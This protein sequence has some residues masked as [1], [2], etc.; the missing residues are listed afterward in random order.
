MA[1]VWQRPESRTW[2]VLH[3]RQKIK[4]GKSQRAAQ[5][6]AD[7]I[8]VA[9]AEKQ[10]GIVRKLIQPKKAQSTDAYLAYYQDFSTKNHRPSTTKRYGAVIRT[11]QTFLQ[12]HF[13]HVTDLADLDP[14]VFERYKIWRKSTPV[15][16]NG[17]PITQRDLERLKKEQGNSIQPCARDNTVNAELSFLRAI[18]N[19]AVREEVLDRSPLQ[20]VRGFEVHDDLPKRILTP[21]QAE[22]LLAYFNE[23]SK[24]LYDVFLMLL[25]TGMRSEEVKHLTWDNVSLPKRIIYIRKVEYTNEKGENEVWIPK[26]RKSKGL[27]QIPMHDKVCEVLKKRESNSAKGSGF[28]FP[29]RHGGVLKTK[30]R[31]ELMRATKAIGIPEFTRVHDLR[32]TFISFMAMQGVP[33]DTIK[34]IVGHVDDETYEIYRETSPEHLMASISKLSF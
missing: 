1:T 3:G 8:N 28:V 16:R 12:R 15:S 19:H 25:Y 20:G 24:D 11:F 22:K 13:P 30:L 21:E 32:R 9:L 17:R 31:R 2:Y 26:S 14:V 6:L 18:F 34:D 33:R 4:V 10:V 7:K 23:R 29:D 5:H 27:R